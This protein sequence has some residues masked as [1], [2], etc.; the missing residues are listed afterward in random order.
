MTNTASNVSVREAP[1]VVRSS[2]GGQAQSG[3][4]P[5]IRG[6]LGAAG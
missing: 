6:G 2:T 4:R 1:I 3:E 5:S